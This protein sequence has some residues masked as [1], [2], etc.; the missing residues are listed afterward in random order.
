MQLTLYSNSSCYCC[1][2]HFHICRAP[3]KIALSV[4]PSVH[5]QLKNAYHIIMKS[6]TVKFYEQLC[7]QFSF[8]SSHLMTT[9]H[10]DLQLLLHICTIAFMLN[11]RKVSGAPYL[12]RSEHISTD[13]LR[14]HF[15]SCFSNHFIEM[16]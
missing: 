12:D 13:T 5:T 9:L 15:L 6:E 16:A 1:W 4:Q 3:I 8:R 14:I 2:E 7:I 10:E 11:T